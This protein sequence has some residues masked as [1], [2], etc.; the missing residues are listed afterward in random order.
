MPLRPDG[1]G[2]VLPTPPELADR[3]IQMPDQLDAPATDQYDATVERVPRDV[4]ERSTWNPDCPV[5]LED[6]RYLT[7]TFWGFDGEHHRGELIVQASAAEGV[8]EVFRRLHAARFPIEEMR[9]VNP[10]DLLAPPTGDGNNTAAFVCRSTTGAGSWSQHAYGLALD[11]NPFHNPYVRGD[12]VVPELASA[13]L[14]RGREA[15]GIIRAG[16]A[17]VEAFAA[18]GWEWG[19]HWSSAKDYQHFSANGR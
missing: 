1:F 18:I 9:V 7:V 10:L 3:R 6:L 14:D 17:V 15:P 11:V 12:L 2:E 4:A 16:D 13:Y 5:G 19:G 8:V